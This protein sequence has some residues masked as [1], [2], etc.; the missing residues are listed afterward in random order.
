MRLA[1][2]A[3]RITDF[4]FLFWEACCRLRGLCQENLLWWSLLQQENRQSSSSATVPQ[5]ICCTTMVPKLEPPVWEMGENTPAAYALSILAYW[6]VWAL[7]LACWAAVTLA[8]FMNLPS[9]LFPRP[10]T[11][12]ACPQRHPVLPAFR[13]L[14]PASS[15]AVPSRSP[16][17]E[18]RPGGAA[19]AVGGLG[20]A[21][22]PAACPRP[23]LTAGGGPAGA[24]R[25]PEVC[26]G[27]HGSCHGAST[28]AKKKIKHAN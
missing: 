4:F 1:K 21:P 3:E 23:P 25:P 27:S 24:A 10:C 14:S 7:S 8:T 2:S 17:A 20:A 28:G 13:S 26:V 15:T 12:E 6:I 16:D 11:P 19:G 5:M 18:H 9:P 22:E